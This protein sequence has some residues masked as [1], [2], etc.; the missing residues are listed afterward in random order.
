MRAETQQRKLPAAIS[1]QIARLN[2]F[3]ITGMRLQLRDCLLWGGVASACEQAPLE[4]MEC[5]WTCAGSVP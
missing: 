5:L 1:G 3:G 4:E 2:G